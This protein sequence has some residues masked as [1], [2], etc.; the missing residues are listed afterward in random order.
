M[1]FELQA[2]R[3]NVIR[4]MKEFAELPEDSAESVVNDDFDIFGFLL[5][6]PVIVELG[7]GKFEII[8]PYGGP[9]YEL[10]TFLSV[11]SRPGGSEVEMDVA[12][13]T[14]SGRLSRPPYVQQLA[15]DSDHTMRDWFIKL[16]AYI[17]QQVQRSGIGLE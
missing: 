2:S 16:D 10:V 5:P 1:K 9:I 3:D 17:A 4:Y 14:P 8:E 15:R 13:R 7:D 12:V 6:T 11:T